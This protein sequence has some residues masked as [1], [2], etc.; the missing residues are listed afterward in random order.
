[1]T[2]GQDV[3]FHL[4][5]A[6]EYDKRKYPFLITEEYRTKKAVELHDEAEVRL[7]MFI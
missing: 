2:N 1:M 4:D 6:Y 5:W 7:K 3:S